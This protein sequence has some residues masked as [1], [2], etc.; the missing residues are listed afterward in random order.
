MPTGV[1]RP[2]ADV[3]SSALVHLIG[4]ADQITCLNAATTSWVGMSLGGEWQGDDAKTFVRWGAMTGQVPAGSLGVARFEGMVQRRPGAAAGGRVELRWTLAGVATP[5]QT[6]RA[7]SAL[8]AW[9]YSFSQQFYVTT[10]QLVAGAAPVGLMEV[11]GQPVDAGFGWYPVSDPEDLFRCNDWYLNVTEIIAP[12]VTVVTGPAGT[13]AG[14]RVTV[15]W[16]CP[17]T[18]DLFRVRLFTQAATAA[19]GFDPA[20]AAAYYDSGERLGEG[21]TSFPVPKDL[22][23][24]TYVPY[25]RTAEKRTLGGLLYQAVDHWG[26]WAAGAAFTIADTPP[27]TS[28]P[29]APGNV[30]DRLTTRAA[31]A[32]PH[33]PTFQAVLFWWDGSQSWPL[34][35]LSGTVTSD[36]RS[37]IRGS[38]ELIVANRDFV[39]SAATTVDQAHP[40]HPFGAYVSLARG[41]GN[42]LVHLGLFRIDSVSLDRTGDAASP[43][44]VTATDWSAWVAD[45]RFTT[46]TT[47]QTWAGAVVTPQLVSEAAAAILEEAKIAG[48]VSATTD[49]VATNYLNERTANRLEALKALADSQGWVCFAQPDGLI[50]FGPG[51][52]PATDP[53]QVALVE[54]ENAVILSQSFTLNRDQVYDVVVASNDQGSVV[55]SAYDSNP[56]SPIARSGSDSVTPWTGAGPFHPSAKPFFFASPVITSVPQ[57]QAAA[58]TTLQR[59]A[60]PS[61]RVEV[62]TVPIP[63]LRVGDVVTLRR[64]N[65]ALTADPTRYV[66]ETLTVP[67]DV[68]AT[69]RLSLVGPA[70]Y[71]AGTPGP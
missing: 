53:V 21:S 47:R 36:A 61:D 15:T 71:V 10:D 38:A 49:R 14:N 63:D 34:D 25:V 7:D 11:R 23:I 69:Q 8:N 50:Y 35:L 42:E 65:A 54:G 45:A 51:P 33:R 56:L 2:T 37:L 70:N 24:G 27:P 29:T 39:P 17:P 31:L 68:E 4:A 48:L 59:V 32:Q 58:V 41:I 28:A 62:A 1:V 22:D 52:A 13:L 67:L 18:T 12:P 60:L 55:G 40:L 46:P 57:A 30:R 64:I 20:T 43:V 16:T 26:L 66:I 44:R 9:E 3:T 19:P 5:V 6:W